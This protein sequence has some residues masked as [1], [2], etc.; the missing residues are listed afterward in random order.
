M[1]K[2]NDEIVV[3]LPSGMKLVTVSTAPDASELEAS[4]PALAFCIAHLATWDTALGAG[5]PVDLTR[6]L[7]LAKR[8]RI[9]EFLGFPGSEKIVKLLSKIEPQ[10][11]SI[12]RLLKLRRKLKE[13]TGLLEVLLHLPRLNR[14]ALFLAVNW[15]W[16]N[17]VTPSLYQELAGQCDERVIP[18][19]ARLLADTMELLK[20]S[21]E[22]Q[23]RR[24]RSV[25]EVQACHDRLVR[26]LNV[27]DGTQ[28]FYKPST[29]SFPPPPLLGTVNIQPII[30]ALQLEEEGREQHH[31]VG[32]FAD[33]VADGE[34]Y[35]YKI[36]APER[37]TVSL[38]KT[39]N[40]WVIAELKATCNSKVS[41]ETWRFVEEWLQTA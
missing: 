4:N 40:G 15:R 11:C 24:F 1:S 23:G 25:A 35:F 27:D 41:P 32:M 31:C 28:Y 12:P 10:A 22:V 39:Q 18:E 20:R 13:E 3:D 17:F 5:N 36:L 29:R 16:G 34:M 26:R 19:A 9:C 30:T 14:Q 6:K 33:Q 8:K 38:E 2:T 37:A 21:P 7:L